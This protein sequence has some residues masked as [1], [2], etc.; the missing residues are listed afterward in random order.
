MKKRILSVLLSMV[1]ATTISSA[2]PM[3]VQAETTSVKTAVQSANTTYGSNTNLGEIDA[4]D[5]KEWKDKRNEA[6]IYAGWYHFKGEYTGWQSVGIQAHNESSSGDYVL[7]TTF[8]TMEIWKKSGSNYEKLMEK[9]YST[10]IDHSQVFYME[11]G[12][13]Y[14]IYMGGVKGCNADLTLGG[15]GTIYAYDAEINEPASYKVLSEKN[16]QQINAASPEDVQWLKFVA[17][18]DGKY[19]LSYKEENNASRVQLFGSS[20]GKLTYKVWYS[21]P[22]DDR[23]YYDLKKGEVCYLA[24]TSFKGQASYKVSVK[25]VTVKEVYANKD[26]AFSV[27]KSTKAS[28]VAAAQAKTSIDYLNKI[29]TPNQSFATQINHADQQDIAAF[30]KM[31]EVI[32]KGCQTE[33]EKV[34]AITRW[35]KKN[36]KYD[37][38]VSSYST[39]V[40][41]SRKGDC[42]GMSMLIADFCRSLG[43]PAA[44]ASGWKADLTMW[45][46]D[47]LYHSYDRHKFAGHGWDM[48][49]FDGKWHMYDVLF[50]NYDVTDSNT[51]AEKGY[52][53]AFIEGMS[54]AGDGLDPALA[55][56]DVGGM[57]VTPCYYQ[58]NFVT[59]VYGRLSDREYQYE[60]DQDGDICKAARMGGTIRHQIL[61]MEDQFFP[62]MTSNVVYFPYSDEISS[63]GGLYDDG[64]KDPDAGYLYTNGW[65]FGEYLADVD[66]VLCN[67]DLK[68]IG[69]K[70]YYFEKNGDAQILNMNTDDYYMYKG[71]LYIKT[72]ASGSIIPTLVEKYLNNS[73][74]VISTWIIEAFDSKGNE[75]NGSNLIKINSKDCTIKTLN[76]GWVWYRIRVRRVDDDENTYLMDKDVQ[77]NITDQ[78]KPTYS[79][80]DT[81][82]S[83]DEK[84]T[85]DD[86]FGNKSDNDKND[87][88]DNKNNNSLDTNSDQTP[89]VNPSVQKVVLT[90]TS[91]IYDGKVKNPA[92]KI[93]DSNGKQLSF[94]D[95][96]ISKSSGRK[97]VGKYKYTITF[98]NGYTGEKTLYFT[99]NPKPT[100][101]TSLKKGSKKMKLKWKKVSSQASGYQIRYSTKSSMSGAK[102][103]TVKKYKTSSKTI[104]RLKKKKKY[105]VQIRT[106]KTV[107]KEK[108][109]SD[110]S[111]RKSV[112]TK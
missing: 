3:N 66:G 61:E 31:A 20:N 11:E 103:V 34:E 51:M 101:L 18:E 12:T 4:K 95:Y 83:S 93:F 84:P 28:T 88:S 99:I 25:K 53:F 49:Y 21:Q 58:G 106:Y 105:Y 30:K 91:Y 89:K 111:A 8:F 97:N 2:V 60:V 96:T 10:G 77:L 40:F 76:S 109:Y 36:I 81:P 71:Q 86:N 79:F 29:Y 35:V 42:Q 50:D 94:K 26:H 80:E 52:Y 69:D 5:I 112:V 64:R 6:D 62:T 92:V 7:G 38:T 37:T 17:P 24:C 33:K 85:P 63:N 59:L 104:S 43:M 110:W 19:K 56:M 67:M 57:L 44:Y 13:D 14:Y 98:K 48:I 15:A 73:N 70:I 47:D 27:R 46:I 100:K 54:I 39:E 78:G 9:D 65:L 55:G 74:Y 90:Q 72:G 1:V 87:S 32:T 41:Q 108:Y 68:T 102:T 45:T 23:S 22:A 75:V 82:P 107:G 16:S